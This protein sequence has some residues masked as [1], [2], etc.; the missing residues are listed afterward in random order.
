[1]IGAVITQPA[2]LT[3]TPPCGRVSFSKALLPLGGVSLYAELHNVANYSTNAQL[4]GGVHRP[5]FPS[6]DHDTP[7]HLGARQDLCARIDVG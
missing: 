4:P 6:S 5:I 7:P 2:L 1:M 3:A